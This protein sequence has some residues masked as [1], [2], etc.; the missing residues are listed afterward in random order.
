MGGVLLRASE[1]S[2]GVSMGFAA[3]QPT[4][5]ATIT[6]TQSFILVFAPK[7]KASGRF[8]ERREVLG[9]SYGLLS[10][11]EQVR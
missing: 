9:S 1:A 4:H 5:R 7:A 11:F 8:V 3:A 6:A 2:A 10:V